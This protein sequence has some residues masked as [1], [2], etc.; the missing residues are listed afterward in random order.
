M[1]TP[2][3]GMGRP[4]LYRDTLSPSLVSYTLQGISFSLVKADF[5]PHH[6]FSWFDE[7]ARRCTFQA[8][9]QVVLMLLIHG[10]HLG[11]RFPF[12]LSTTELPYQPLFKTILLYEMSRSFGAGNLPTWNSDFSFWV[13]LWYE[14]LR[15]LSSESL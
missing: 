3:L 14:Y 6:R 8:S 2:M 13:I 10:P 1:L 12:C 11:T 4:L 5:L 7:E 15:I 9:F